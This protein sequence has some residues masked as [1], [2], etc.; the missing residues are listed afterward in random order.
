L[1]IKFQNAVIWSVPKFK[2]SWRINRKKTWKGAR[3]GMID[4]AIGG[5][6]QTIQIHVSELVY[7]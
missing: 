7:K 4:D 6:D 5:R 1:A 2:R 3:Y